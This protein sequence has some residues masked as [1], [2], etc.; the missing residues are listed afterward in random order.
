MNFPLFYINYNFVVWTLKLTYSV[1]ICWL[2]FL[3]NSALFWRLLD[4]KWVN[5]VSRHFRFIYHSR[6]F[7]RTNQEVQDHFQLIQNY[8]SQHLTELASFKHYS[9]PGRQTYKHTRKTHNDKREFKKLLRRRRSQC[10]LKMNLYFTSESRDTLKSFT[11]FI[12]VKAI[13]RLNLGHRNEFEIEFW[14]ISR[15]SSRSSGNA[16]LVIS[17]FCLAEDGKEMYKE[18]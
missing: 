6:W 18:L 17:R 10:R 1:L 8:F 2:V 12:T 7:S 15:R 13:P 11:L 5:C 9:E 4:H 3:F 16:E 14:K